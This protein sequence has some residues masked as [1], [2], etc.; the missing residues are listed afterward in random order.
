MCAAADEQQKG[1]IRS[2]TGARA[3]EQEGR[4]RRL[5]SLIAHL[6]R[7]FS[8]LERLFC[9]LLHL[10]TLSVQP[11]PAFARGMTRE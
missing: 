5:D 1:S 10:Q 4:S 9:C 2:T 8:P 7:F 6:L 11:S 3:Q